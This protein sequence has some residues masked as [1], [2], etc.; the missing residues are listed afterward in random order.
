MGA[1]RG[2]AQRVGMGEPLDLR[3][4]ADVLSRFGGHR[5][6][7]G[8]AEPEQVGLLG[9]LAAPAGDLGEAA[10]DLAQLLEAAAVGGE[11]LGDLVPGIAVEQ[12]A[13]AGRAQQTLLVVLAVH[14]DEVLGELA[15]QP[16][17]GGAPADERPRAPFGR[18]GTGHDQYAGV[19]LS[20]RLQRPGGRG[21]VGIDPDPALDR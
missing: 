8:Q 16:D 14:R 20:P 13:L 3:G 1:G 4:Q 18:D 19:E 17:R 9:A 11:R 10:P 15:E 21:G 2:G 5:L 6:D 12:V 7:L